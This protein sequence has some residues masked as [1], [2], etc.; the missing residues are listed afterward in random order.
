MGWNGLVT[1]KRLISLLAENIRAYL[2]GAPV[3]VVTK[4]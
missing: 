1:R 2:N 3:N 4:R